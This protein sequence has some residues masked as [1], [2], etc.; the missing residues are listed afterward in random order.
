MYCSAGRWTIAWPNDCL[1]VFWSQF[2]PDPVHRAN[3]KPSPWKSRLKSAQFAGEDCSGWC[4]AVSSLNLR[5][6]GFFPPPFRWWSSI[7]SWSF[8]WSWDDSTLLRY[9]LKSVDDFSND[10]LQ[11]PPSLIPSQKMT[12]NCY[13]VALAPDY[14]ISLSI[15]PSLSPSLSLVAQ[16]HF[17]RSHSKV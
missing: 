15:C 4:K 1:P 17:K 5:R 14:H 13:W 2:S 10:L 7:L 12:E 6:G 9:Y 16:V 11:M 8:S 3:Y